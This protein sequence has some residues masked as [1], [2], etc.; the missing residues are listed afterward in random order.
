MH[1][2]IFDLSKTQDN[3]PKARAS[4][5]GL[6]RERAEAQGSSVQVGNTEAWSSW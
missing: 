4:Q 3:A 1:F 5:E 2:K 6:A